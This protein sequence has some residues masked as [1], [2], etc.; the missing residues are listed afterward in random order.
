M[1]KALITGI[2]GQDGSYLAQLL[3]RKNY[4]VIG[5]V[6]AKNDIGKANIKDFE[7]K[8]ILE[9]GDLLDKNSLEKIILKHKPDE[10]YNLAGISFIPTSW[11]KPALTYDVNALGPLRILQIIKDHNLTSKFFQASSAK[12]FAK[13]KNQSQNEET[14]YNPVDPYG[15]SKLSAHLSTQLFRRQ[16]KLFASC[17]ILFNHE[18]ER[19]GEDFVTR[20]ITLAAAKIKLGLQKNLALGNLASQ[21]DWGYAPDYVRGMWQI[22]QADKPDDFVL[23]TGKLHSVADVCQIAFSHLGLNYQDYVVRDPQFYRPN[24]PKS[25]YGDPTKAQKI[26]GWK[27]QTSFEKMIENMTEYDLSYFQTQNPKS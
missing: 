19:R 2:T 4:Q 18:S 10:I 9:T 8:L 12:I 13:S 16:F 26:L 23:S 14:A 11:A 17:A 22:L 21:A 24:L 15:V 6:S 3:L 7:D 1:K 27:R 5:L 20:K 25:Y